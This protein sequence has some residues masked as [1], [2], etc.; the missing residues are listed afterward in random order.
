MITS[1][2]PEQCYIKFNRKVMSKKLLRN[3]RKVGVG[4]VGVGWGT[5]TTF[6]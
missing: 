6:T 4:E 5:G 2:N 3:Q 1:Q